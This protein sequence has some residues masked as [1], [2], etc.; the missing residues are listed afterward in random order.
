MR[1]SDRRIISVYLI[2]ILISGIFGVIQSPEPRNFLGELGDGIDGALIGI[3]LTF[4]EI[5]MR[6]VHA[7]KLRRFKPWKIV[8]FR[9]AVYLAVFY[10]VPEIM[11][12]VMQQIWPDRNIRELVGQHHLFLYFA[13]AMVV[14]L[15]MAIRRMLGA[16]NLLAM[17]TGRYR[18]PREEEHIVAFVDLKGSTPLAERLGPSRFHD[19]LNDVFFDAAGPIIDLGGEVYQYVGDEIVVTWSAARGLKNGDCVRFFFALEDAL[20]ERREAYLKEYGE[21]PSLRGALHIGPLMVGEIG[22]LNRQ[23]VMIGDT[24]NTAARIE[25]ACRKF[26]RDYVA[27]AS[28]L[29]RLAQLPEAIRAE[30]LGPVPLAGKSGEME[31]F[32]LS[33]AN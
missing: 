8:L 20:A 17:T 13:F 6:D 32:A 15:F 18:R 28:I 30:S 4:F 11:G 14:N 1:A 22:D 21:V 26:G 2:V 5:Q 25:G 24:M 23:I 31:L 10:F 16:K 29:V 12:R 19:F 33:R 27:S 3:A 9:F 7:R